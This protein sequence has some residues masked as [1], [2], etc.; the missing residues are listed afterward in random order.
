[1]RGAGYESGSCF[2]DRTGG[3]VESDI[4]QL[5]GK[6]SRAGAAVSNSEVVIWCFISLYKMRKPTSQLLRG[7]LAGS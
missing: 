5:R 4:S 3:L 6:T 1:M 2:F 7:V